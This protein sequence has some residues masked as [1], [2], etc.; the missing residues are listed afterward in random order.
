MP[1]SAKIADEIRDLRAQAELYRKLAATLFDRRTANELQRY[2]LELET[3]RA[4]LAAKLEA[5]VPAAE[6]TG[7]PI[8]VAA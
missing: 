8:E 1:S 5:E 2:A 4:E 6:K 7:R 3:E